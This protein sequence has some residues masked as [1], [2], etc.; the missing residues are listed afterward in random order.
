MEWKTTVN[1]GE[2]SLE[3]M[4][5][6]ENGK[7]VLARRSVHLLER[8]QPGTFIRKTMNRNYVIQAR[9]EK[10]VAKSSCEISSLLEASESILGSGGCPQ[11][12]PAFGL[13]N[14][15]LSAFRCE[16]WRVVCVCPRVC[17]LGLLLLENGVLLIRITMF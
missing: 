15:V 7:K 8:G 17:V 9:I 16:R 11:I 6:K 4:K 3:K 5:W 2:K 12:N 10:Q 1:A 14:G 13:A